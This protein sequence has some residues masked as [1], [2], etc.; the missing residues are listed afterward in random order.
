MVARLERDYLTIMGN[1]RVADDLLHPSHQQ[2]PALSQHA[3][4]IIAI[5]EDD[6]ELATLFQD[7]LKVQQHWH[8]HFFPDG[9]VARDTIPQLQPQ[10][11]LLDVGLPNLDGAALYKILRGHSATRHIPILVITGKHDWQLHRMGLQAGLFLRKPF[12]LREL[13]FMMQALLGETP[14]M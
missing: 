8:L 9:Q 12:K 4:K 6:P 10:L 3:S 1:V 14:P 7:A 5:V 11:I 2:Q 13:L